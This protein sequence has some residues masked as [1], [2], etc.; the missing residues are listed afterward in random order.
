MQI[1][2]ATHPH[3]LLQVAP[4]LSV[5]NLA[6]EPLGTQRL[7]VPV[8]LADQYIPY[9]FEKHRVFP[10]WLRFQEAILVQVFLPVY[11]RMQQFS[12]LREAAACPVIP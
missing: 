7:P 12:M 1:V 9:R 10:E 3:F 4:V 8:K 11:R 5:G 2:E 6:G